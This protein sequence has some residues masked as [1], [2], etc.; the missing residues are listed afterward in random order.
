[1]PHMGDHLIDNDSS[2]LCVCNIETIF[3]IN[4]VYSHIIVY[5]TGNI[6]SFMSLTL[7][8]SILLLISG[9]AFAASFL[10]GVPP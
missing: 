2:D 3:C 8:S 7:S 4:K 5:F 10:E 9:M 6:L 1:M